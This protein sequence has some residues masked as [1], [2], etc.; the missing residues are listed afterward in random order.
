LL[1]IA[2]SDNGY[3]CFEWIPT[4][5][6]PKVINYSFVKD[7]D[8]CLENNFEKVISTFKSNS[9]DASNSLSFTINIKNVNISSFTIDNIK[10]A[11]SSIDWYEKNILNESYLNKYK[12]F[13]YPMNSVENHQ[14][15]LTIAIDRNLR[16]EIQSIASNYS[17]KLMYLSVDIFSA[18]ISMQQLYKIPKDKDVLIWKIDKNNCHYLT[19]Y[20]NDNLSSLMVFRLN[21]KSFN[22]SKKIG[23]S[24]SIMMLKRF[25]DTVLIKDEIFEEIENIFVYQ[26]KSNNIFIKNIL[27]NKETNIR[28]LDITKI[29]KDD[30]NNPYKL[31]PYIENGI[32]LRGVD[33]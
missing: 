26:N 9:R 13:Y 11:N 22:I 2:Q 23:G 31:M 8:C 1:S 30:A 7:Y 5:K 15:M 3:N 18:Y 4:E 20:T 12:I 10:N 14:E 29:F 21:K 24:D 28:L 25:I 32:S 16:N 6:G 27:K 17:Y 33:V 19:Y